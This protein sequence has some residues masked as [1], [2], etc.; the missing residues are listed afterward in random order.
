MK[1]FKGWGLFVAL[2][3]MALLCACDTLDGGGKSGIAG[4]PNPSLEGLNPDIIP[5]GAKLTVEF[6]DVQPPMTP[7]QTTVRE[8]GTITLPYNISVKAAN[9]TTGDVAKEIETL[10]VPKYFRRL[11]V[12]IKRDDL[13][14]T[15]TGQV[16]TP[17]PKPYLGQMTVLKAVAAAGDF[18]DFARKTHV[19]LTRAN[20]K[21][22]NV[23][24]EK[25]LKKP[26]L[27]LPVYPGDS[28]YVPIRIW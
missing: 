19:Q 8:D 28:I 14:V 25:A 18:T 20:G 23:N 17:G 9:R 15:V 10:Y 24:A 22:I 12:N 21:K 2:C 1:T 4:Q 7:F 27:D 6:S 3:L 13:Y 5:K 26:E 16:K 11:T